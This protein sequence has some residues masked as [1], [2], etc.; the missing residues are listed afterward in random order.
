MGLEGEE[1]TAPS[2]GLNPTYKTGV[3]KSMVV[4][5]QPQTA[6]VFVWNLRGRDNTLTRK[7]IVSDRIL[8]CCF[9]VGDRKESHKDLKDNNKS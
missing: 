8:D 6:Y 2:H 5:D 1:S 3:R 9:S 7:W 4:N